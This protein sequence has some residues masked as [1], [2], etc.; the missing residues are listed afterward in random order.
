MRGGQRYRGTA[1]DI[2]TGTCGD[3][4]RRGCSGEYRL[5]DVDVRRNE[6]HVRVQDDMGGDA[7]SM[8]M[9]RQNSVPKSTMSCELE[10]LNFAGLGIACG[11]V[12]E[13]R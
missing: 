5:H 13:G 1:F 3:R 4:A 10:G 6:D 2:D 7:Q 12:Y 8:A 9:N 11:F